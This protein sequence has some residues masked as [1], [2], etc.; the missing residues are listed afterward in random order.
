MDIDTFNIAIC[1]DDKE[2]HN[3]IIGLC[4]SFFIG[5][6]VYYKIYSY[7]LGEEIIKETERHSFSCSITKMVADLYLSEKTKIDEVMRERNEYKKYSY[8]R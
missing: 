2:L 5:K 4:N 3:E 8:G 7:F 1:D 6:K